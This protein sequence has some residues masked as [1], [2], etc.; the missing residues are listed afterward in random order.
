MQTIKNLGRVLELNV[1][2]TDRVLRIDFSDKRIVGNVLRLVKKYQNMDTE[3]AERYDA[4]TTEDPIDKLIAYS[5]IEE[6]VLT[7]FKK[8]VDG[9]FNTNITEQLFG[10]T[11]PGVERYA[12]LFSIIVPFL[13]E[14]KKEEDTAISELNRLYNT[15][16][17]TVVEGNG[18]AD[19]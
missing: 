5:E 16:K 10:D 7:T 1:E 11:L 2:G 8:D 9:A 14:Y 4:V 3:L 19:V 6:D 13:Q 17:F 15:D 12:E 18:E